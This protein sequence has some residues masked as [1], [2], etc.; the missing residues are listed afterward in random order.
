MKDIHYTNGEPSPVAA[1]ASLPSS[2]DPSPLLLVDSEET[3]LT[4]ISYLPSTWSV[5]TCDPTQ[6]DAQSYLGHTHAIIW[7]R[8]DEGGRAWASTLAERIGLPHY[9]VDFGKEFPEHWDLSQP[10]PAGKTHEM[11]TKFFAVCIQRCKPPKPKVNGASVVP[12]YITDPDIPLPEELRPAV[13]VDQEEQLDFIRSATGIIKPCMA[14]A[15]YLLK[16]YP[17]RWP[18]RFD[19]FSNRPFLG[20]EPMTDA[21]MRRV[22]V[23]IQQEGVL[24]GKSVCD[25]A[26]LTVAERNSFHPVRE[27]LDSLSWD[28]I[29]RLDHFLIDHVGCQDDAFGLSRTI[30][31]KWMIQAVARIY[32]PGCQADAM[33]ILEGPQGLKKSSFFRALFGDRW[34]TDH[35][36]NL[37]DKDAMLQLGG[38]W[39]VEVSELATLDRSDSAKIK[40]FLTSRIDRFRAPFGRLVADN[41]RTSVFAGTINPGAQGYLKDP[42]GGRRFWPIPA[43]EKADIAAI[44]TQRD[45]LWAEAVHR[46]RSHEAWWVTEEETE[47]HKQLTARQEA[48]YEGDAWTDVI[49]EYVASRDF[50]TC[51]D[52]FRDVLKLSSPADWKRGDEMRVAKCFGELKWVKRRKR[53]NGKPRWGYERTHEADP[54]G[55]PSLPELDGI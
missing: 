34:F 15:V 38:V 40:Q 55:Q 54:I 28:G 27:Y 41:P 10:L 21:D 36:P 19:L 22:A 18:L 16:Q 52:I 1:A 45:Q 46:Y 9:I 8:N 20:N 24:A 44:S 43:A 42:T 13:A 49:A 29:D 26:I 7:P 31:R 35:L 6:I 17:G 32:E 11:L 30:G 4:S 47:L 2:H 5:F 37:A 33:L 3:R 39:C 14:N 48:R 25:E 12:A 23:W 50:V 51:E 53:K